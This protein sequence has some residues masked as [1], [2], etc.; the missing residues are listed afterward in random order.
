[1]QPKQL[2]RVGSLVVLHGLSWPMVCRI[3]VPQPGIKPVS[4]ALEGRLST[5]GPLGK[6][7]A[8]YFKREVTQEFEKKRKD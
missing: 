2:H 1:M 5:T 6:S 7:L 3:L 4:P 8:G